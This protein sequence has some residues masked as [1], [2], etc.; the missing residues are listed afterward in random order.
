MSYF[1]LAQIIKNFDPIQIPL[2]HIPVFL[3]LTPTTP[4]PIGSSYER[5]T[6]GRYPKSKV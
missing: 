2:T 4:R 6:F 5:L 3:Y 1:Q